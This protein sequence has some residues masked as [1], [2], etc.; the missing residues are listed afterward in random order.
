MGWGGAWYVPH[1]DFG[2][3]RGGN[4]VVAAGRLTRFWRLGRQRFSS[5][6][7][8]QKNWID[9]PLCPFEA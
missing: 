4:E 3:T 6:A 1:D 5:H 2:C 8:K 7:V 9:Q